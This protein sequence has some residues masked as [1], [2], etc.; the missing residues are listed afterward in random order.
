MSAPT[1]QL[2][3]KYRR[4]DTY[5]LRILAT[6][7]LY[8]AAPESLNDP[9]DCQLPVLALLDQ[10][11]ASEVAGESKNLLSILRDFKVTNRATGDVELMHRTFETL[12]SSTGVLSLSRN[13]T[14]ALLWSHY[15]DGHRGFC[16]G[17]DPGYFTA[18]TASWRQYGLLGASDV[19]YV[20]APLDQFRDL[21]LQKAR[22]IEAIRNASSKDKE[23]AISEF[24]E[25]YKRD[26][27]VTVLTTK[28]KHWMYE[29]EYRAVKAHSGVIAFP[30]SALREV[31]FGMRLPESDEMTIRTLLDHREWRHVRFFRPICRAGTFALELLDC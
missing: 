13:P 30:P 5:S 25:S 27:I 1:P 20:E 15:A 6:K 12:P 4:V 16:I 26:V 8:F 23:A 29:R 3:Y 14:D 22:D 10:V 31:V 21:W 9:L 2:L 18:L 28:S 11:I 7:E 17:F 19:S 24:P